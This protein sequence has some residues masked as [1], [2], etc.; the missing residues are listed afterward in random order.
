MWF[1][2][3][4]PSET[5]FL[6]PNRLYAS[7]P[8]PVTTTNPSTSADNDSSDSV[9]GQVPHQLR[10]FLGQFK[11]MLLVGPSYDKCTGCSETVLKAYEK[12]GFEML[13][14]AFNDTKYLETLTGLD[15]LFDEGEEALE[16]VDWDED[17]DF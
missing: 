6:I 4:F 13:V 12:E 14:K 16:K 3:N 7:A 17:E 5:N 1:C 8:P 11:T 15:K 10:G 9:L 2:F